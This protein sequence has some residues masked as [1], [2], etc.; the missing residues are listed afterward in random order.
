MGALAEWILEASRRAFM[1][2][3]LR[4]HA[5]PP[6]FGQVCGENA[7]ETQGARGAF[8]RQR[9]QPH[10]PIGF[11]SHLLLWVA[12]RPSVLPP[13]VAGFWR[14]DRVWI[15]PERRRGMLA[16]VGGPGMV[17]SF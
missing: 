7:L 4:S 15:S 10:N 13:H 17:A 6:S 3:I 11:A 1:S 12:L 2:P 14:P 8:L 16:E 9:R 5:H